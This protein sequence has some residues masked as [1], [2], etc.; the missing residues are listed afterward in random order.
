MYVSDVDVKTQLSPHRDETFILEPI[1]QSDY[2]SGHSKL[3]I[4]LLYSFDEVL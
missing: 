2:G 4:P 3:H 1:T